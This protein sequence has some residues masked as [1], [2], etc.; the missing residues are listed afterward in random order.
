MTTKQKLSKDNPYTTFTLPLNSTVADELRDMCQRADSAADCA[1]MPG[2]ECFD[3]VDSSDEDNPFGDM[4]ENES[5]V[6]DA[7]FELEDALNEL[8]NTLS[9]VYEQTSEVEDALCRLEEAQEALTE[10]YEE[11]AKEWEK[12]HNPAKAQKAKR[13]TKVKKAK[14]AARKA[15]KAG[16]Q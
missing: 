16:A 14:K 12:K 7:M 13:K 6:D 10:E 2:L 1:S 5:A 9:S 8:E 15:R 3:P 11:R 4:S